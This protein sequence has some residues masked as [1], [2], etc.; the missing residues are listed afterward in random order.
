MEAN[1][2][3]ELANEKLK[4]F[5][6]NL[7]SEELNFVD[8]PSDE[9]SALN[10]VSAL[11]IYCSRDKKTY[12]IGQTNTLLRRHNEHLKEKEKIKNR[13]SIKKYKINKKY[14]KDKKYRNYF[15]GGRLII[16]Y[17]ENIEYYLNYLERS[18]IKIFSYFKFSRWK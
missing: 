5:I 4:Y 13:K 1:A 7:D 3:R 12:Y 14:N 2:Y 10:D 11:Y 16:F 17:G 6:T 8:I 18:L 15:G 9:V